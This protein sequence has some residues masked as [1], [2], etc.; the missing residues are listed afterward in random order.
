ML[1]GPG[2]GIGVN[3][4]SP[5]GVWGHLEVGLE[6]HKLIKSINELIK[7]KQTR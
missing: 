5:P 2:V 1:T 3:V 4:K 6:F 7:T